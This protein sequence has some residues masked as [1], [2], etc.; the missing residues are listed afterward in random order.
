MFVGEVVV[1]F[2]YV[3]FCVHIF[4]HFNEVALLDVAQRELVLRRVYIVYALYH[5]LHCNDTVRPIHSVPHFTVSLLELWCRFQ[6]F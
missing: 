5:A 2:V 1:H 4:Q 6:K 3:L